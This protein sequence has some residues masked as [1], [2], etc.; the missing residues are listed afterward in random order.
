MPISNF[1][2]TFRRGVALNA[3]FL[4]CRG[5]KNFVQTFK[6]LGFWTLNQHFSWPGSHFALF[7]A[8]FRFLCTL[9]LDLLHAVRQPTGCPVTTG[10]PSARPAWNKCAGCI[11]CRHQCQR[12]GPRV[13]RL[14]ARLQAQNCAA[15]SIQGPLQM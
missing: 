9:S 8:V 11:F 7:Q 1:V 4:W 5:L 15:K 3:L 6:F 10:P 14:H 12:R 2:H 13:L